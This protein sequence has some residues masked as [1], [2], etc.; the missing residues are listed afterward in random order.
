MNE[1]AYAGSLGEPCARCH[2]YE[3]GYSAGK[4]KAENEI[5]AAAAERRHAGDCGCV[6]CAV[7]RQLIDVGRDA[8]ET[9]IVASTRHPAGC[10]C[11]A[12]ALLRAADGDDD[13]DDG[14]ATATA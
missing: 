4:S 14:A 5:V 6:S 12:C 7:V 13:D 3:I 9:E 1:H 8:V 11:R 10:G 2:D